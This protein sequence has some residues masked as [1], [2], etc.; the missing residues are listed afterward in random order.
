M[1]ALANSKTAFLRNIRHSSRRSQTPR[2]ICVAE[3]SEK[4]YRWRNGRRY[5]VMESDLETSEMDNDASLWEA[6]TS[7]VTNA[8]PQYVDDAVSPRAPT[9]APMEE[10]LQGIEYQPTK[11]EA[12][13]PSP[14]LRGATPVGTLR[15]N[16]RQGLNIKKADFTVNSLIDKITRKKLDLRP[17]YQREQGPGPLKPLRCRQGPGPLKPSRCRQGPGPLKPSPK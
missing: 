12:T 7:P 4:I 13:G 3:A 2:Q 9:R 10:P 5:E 17:A 1:R 16:H 14:R 11:A 15:Q 6:L 8:P